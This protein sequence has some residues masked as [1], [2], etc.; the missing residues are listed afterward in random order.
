M[1]TTTLYFKSAKSDKVYIATLKGNVATFFFGR[2]GSDLQGFEYTEDSKSDAE[3]LYSD[4]V[5][6]K[7]A[8]GYTTTEP[9]EGKAKGEVTAIDAPRQVANF[10]HSAAGKKAW[11]KIAAIRALAQKHG[12]T[13]AE[14]AEHFANGTNPKAKVAKKAK[15]A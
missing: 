6:E 9:T 10:D 14:A 5:A 11:V 4:K 3:K 8:E 12:I 2:R 1:K 15:A 7:L 13:Y